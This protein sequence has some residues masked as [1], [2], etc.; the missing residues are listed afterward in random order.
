MLL[1]VLLSSSYSYAHEEKKKDTAVKTEVA[2]KL[3]IGAYITALALDIGSYLSTTLQNS[4]WGAGEIDDAVAQRIDKIA[5]TYNFKN[6]PAIKQAY[7]VWHWLGGSLFSNHSILFIDKELA[8]TIRNIE[9][10]DMGYHKETERKVINQLVVIEHNRDLNI[11]IAALTIPLLTYGLLKGC[12]VLLKKMGQANNALV[13]AIKNGIE[14]CSSNSIIIGL[15]S[16][17]MLYGFI[18]AQD[19]YLVNQAGAIVGY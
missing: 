15:C 13:K 3:F 10:D 8:Q 6:T 5:L 4:I 2:T 18:K 12:N 1:I 17:S 14:Y 9:Y 11:I 19:W 16:L 7:S